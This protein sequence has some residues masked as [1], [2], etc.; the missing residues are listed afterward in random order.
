ME[1]FSNAKDFINKHCNIFA[2]LGLLIVCY[3]VYFM[4]IGN[5]AL[6]DV[7]ETRYVSMARDMFNTK[8]FSTLYLNGEYFFEKPPLYFWS[9]CISFAI[10]GKV[11]EFTARFPVAM[12][13]TFATFLTYFTGKKLISRRFGLI[14]AL[15]LTTTLEFA[16]LARFAI[17]DIVVTTLIGFSVIFGFLTQF[18][19]VKNKKYM[20]WL[21]YIFSGLAVMAKGIP[22]LVIPFGTMFFV[23]LFNRTLKDCFKPVNIIPGFILFFLIILPWHILMLNLH[24]PLFFNEYIMKHHINRFFSSSEIDRKEPFYFYIITLLWGAIPYVFSAIAVFIANLKGFKK[25]KNLDVSALP[26]NIKFVWFNVIASCFTLAFFSVSSTKLIT[27]ILP[28]Y[29]FTS[30]VMGYIWMKYIYERKFEFSINLSVYIFGGILVS[31]SAIACFMKFYLPA[32]VYADIC[33]IQWFCVVLTAFLGIFSLLFVLKKCYKGV[34]VSYVI[35]MMFLAG[36]GTKLFYDLD[37]KF[38]QNDLMTFAKKIKD[39]NQEL[40]VINNWRKYSVLYYY[41]GKVSYLSTMQPDGRYSIGSNKIFQKDARTIIKKKDYLWF[42]RFYNFD[43]IASGRKYL[44]IRLTSVR[45]P[46]QTF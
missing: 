21:F 42:K 11:N 32:D 16:M 10:F 13:G 14:S 30:F 39:D 5:Y 18:V 1:I 36:I 19:L 4:N 27:Y 44:L 7:D 37:Y 46:C 29:L 12:Y 43:I 41:D 22:G 8:N 33:S 45:R 28:I 26:D 17:I 9:E 40:C 23:T 25:C 20:W 2:I 38:G 3:F 15:I 6:M 34:F 35:F 31:A 24:D